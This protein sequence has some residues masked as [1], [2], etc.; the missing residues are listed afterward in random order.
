MISDLEIKNFQSHKHTVLEFDPGVNVIVGSSDSGKTAVIRALRWLMTNRPSGDAFC[1]TWMKKEDT[2]FVSVLIDE[3]VV[4]RQE[5]PFKSYRLNDLEFRAFGL[6][7]PNEIVNALNMNEINLQ[8]QMDSPF[9][10]SSSPGDVAAHFNKIARLDMIDTGLQNIQRTIKELTSDINYKK[11]SKEKLTADL[12]QFSH[13]TKLEAEVEVLE[14]LQ[15]HLKRKRSKL[16]DLNV[17]I[18]RLNEIQNTLE[19]KT[20]ILKI[21]KLLNKILLFSEQVRVLKLSFRKLDNLIAD[22]K[23]DQA[24]LASFTSILKSG[25]QI[26]NLLKL[27]EGRNALNQQLNLLKKAL[28]YINDTNILLKQTEAEFDRFH[29]QF[30]FEMGDKCLLCGQKIKQ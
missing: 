21:E 17:L 13:L 2:S 16:S 8:G 30:D 18:S 12:E 27:T 4:Y 20:D 6:T 23:K 24:D 11:Q 7:V 1:S 3:D 10:L 14:E 26:S 29:A 15:I 25:T 5:R 28:T 22:L 19:E 9:L